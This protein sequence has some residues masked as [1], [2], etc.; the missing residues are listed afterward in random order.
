MDQDSNEKKQF[1]KNVM[2]LWTPE[3]HILYPSSLK[4]KIY[5][6]LL[7]ESKLR[8]QEKYKLPKELWYKINSFIKR[9]DI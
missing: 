7:I 3:R 9:E 2:G 6:L 5:L 1:I 8:K 4:N